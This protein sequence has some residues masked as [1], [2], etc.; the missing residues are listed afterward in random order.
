M[1]K[2]AR[3]IPGGDAWAKS[4]TWGC[5]MRNM[6]ACMCMRGVCVRDGVGVG[7]NGGVN[8]LACLRVTS[9]RACDC[10]ALVCSP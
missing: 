5:G 6:S 1:G 2:G 7:W 4:W 10:G 9:K 8:H 3:D